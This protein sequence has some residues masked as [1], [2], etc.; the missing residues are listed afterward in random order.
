MIICRFR[1]DV[2]EI[3]RYEALSKT[4]ILDQLLLETRELVQE[5]VCTNLSAAMS[6]ITDFCTYRVLDDETEQFLSCPRNTNEFNKFVLTFE[7]FDVMFKDEMSRSRTNLINDY[8]QENDDTNYF[9]FYV[10]W[11]SRFSM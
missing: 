10:K 6:F 5:Q 2:R 8:S 7:K 3:E 9:T 11:N 1:K 4:Q